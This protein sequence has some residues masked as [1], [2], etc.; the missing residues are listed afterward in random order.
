MLEAESNY[1]QALEQLRAI[2][3]AVVQG[4]LIGASQQARNLLPL[5]RVDQFEDAVTLR[6][7]VDALKASVQSSRSKLAGTLVGA[8]RKRQGCGTYQSI[9]GDQE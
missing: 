4:D 5:L 8:A 9:Q 2:E 1:Q 7:K 3:H 6:A